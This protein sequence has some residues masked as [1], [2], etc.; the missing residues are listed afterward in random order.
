MVSAKTP[1]SGVGWDA[2]ELW[3]QALFIPPPEEIQDL[4]RDVTR[5]CAQVEQALLQQRRYAH[6]VLRCDAAA[7]TEL[8]SC[9]PRSR[10]QARYRPP[11]VASTSQRPSTPADATTAALDAIERWTRRRSSRVLVRATKSATAQAPS[12]SSAPP[13]SSSSSS[14]S[15]KIPDFHQEL[16]ENVLPAGFREALAP[17]PVD[18]APQQLSLEDVHTAI[19]YVLNGV[20]L[21]LQDDAQRPL[22]FSTSPSARRVLPLEPVH[23]YVVR[24]YLQHF[25][26]AEVATAR[27]LDLLT[28]TNHLDTQSCKVHLFARLLGLPGVPTLSPDGCW[29]VLK[30]LHVLQRCCAQ[31]GHYFLLDAEGDNEFVPQASASEAIGLLFAAASN[32]VIKRLRLKLAGLA[33][34]YGAVWIPA[35]N[36]LTLL[37]DEWTTLQDALRRNV[38]Q[39]LLELEME[40]EMD[41][42]DANEEGD[43]SDAAAAAAAESKRSTA[44]AVAPSFAQFLAG[45]EA[46][47][48][49]VSRLDAVS[50][51]R[52]LLRESAK[53]SAP[54]FQQLWVQL[55]VRAVNA[56]LHQTLQPPSISTA[57]VGG[58]ASHSANGPGVQLGA[59]PEA[60]RA[61]NRQLAAK[62]LRM[63]WEHLKPAVIRQLDARLQDVGLQVRLVQQMEIAVADAVADAAAG[64]AGWRSL[65]QLVSIAYDPCGGSGHG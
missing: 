52:E 53:E 3:D 9:V 62:F 12:L 63:S 37:L 27:L 24:V 8:S 2:Q 30:A 56:A 29:F 45:F 4:E 64:A 15:S 41:D 39:R 50:A 14:S 55:V 10:S 58:S 31:S 38:E 48:L 54:R 20:W 65:Q 60:L 36:I 47:E 46:L 57:L 7:Q 19:S 32:E 17:L 49:P 18:Y 35:Y 51:Y 26:A 33:S 5:L 61:A 11:P 22:R 42:G 23:E 25:R 16:L 59:V 13:A 34:V 6:A 44:S 28:S 1:D 21:L 43:D 40:T